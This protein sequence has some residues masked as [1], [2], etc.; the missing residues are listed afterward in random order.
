MAEDEQKNETVHRQTTG[1]IPNPKQASP[2]DVMNSR[3]RQTDFQKDIVQT[4]DRQAVGKNE[5]DKK[6][7]QTDKTDTN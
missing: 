1:S 2:C 4:K 3:N 5:P 7:E 6:N